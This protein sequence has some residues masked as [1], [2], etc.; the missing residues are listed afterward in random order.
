[1]NERNGEKP[2]P[3]PDWWLLSAGDGWLMPPTASYLVP[4]PKAYLTM[5]DYL[6]SQGGIPIAELL[7]AQPA[8]V[9]A[10]RASSEFLASKGARAAFMLQGIHG[11]CE[12]WRKGGRLIDEILE[13]A[14]AVLPKGEGRE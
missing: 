3:D 12:P 11:G 7:V 13:A 6:R 9:D 2:W 4:R 1:M 14:L 5:N 10:V 8:L